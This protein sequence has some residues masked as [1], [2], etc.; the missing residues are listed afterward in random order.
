MKKFIINIAAGILPALVLVSSCSKKID[1]AYANPNTPVQATLTVPVKVPVESLLPGIIGCMVGSS[2]VQGSAYG[3][4]NDGLYIGRYVQYW[5]TS[6]SGNQFDQMGGATGA[7]DILGSVWAMH[8]YGMG[9]NLS[10][11]I[12][13]SIE[14]KKWDYAGVGYAIR[15]WSWLMLTDVYGEVI[16]KEAFNTQQSVFNYDPQADVYAKVKEQCDSAIFY[17]SKTG[18][19][20]SQANLAKGDAYFYNGDVNKWKKFA[21]SVMA[22]YY[23][24]Y[25]NKPSLYKPDSVIYYANLG[26][27]AIDDEAVA[28]FA[29]S[30][31]TGTS[32]FYGPLRN[33]VGALRQSRFISDLLTG[34]NPR[35]PG[36]TDPRAGYLIRENTNGTYK[37]VRPN[38]GTDGLVAADQP[39]SFWG[40]PFA[41]NAA[42]AND[43]NC[44]YIFRNG[45]PFPILTASEVMF[46]KAEAYLRKG[47][48]VNAL[49]AYQQGIG[50]SFDML[51]STPDYHTPVPATRQITPALKTAYLTN[52][53]VVPSAANLTLSHI[54]L[55]KF[56][57]MYGYGLIET[58]TDLRRYHYT[59]MDPAFPGQ[60][61][62]AGFAPPIGIDLFSNNNGKWVNRAR[63]R[64]NSEYLYNVAALSSIGA[65]ALDY[66][67]KEMWITQP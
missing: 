16:M 29:N 40:Q 39:V 7:S 20:V 54:M 26:I 9:L 6:A 21:Y 60:Q 31:I 57:A 49:A 17:L 41:T 55:Q 4:A 42:P 32:N 63:P 24:H 34:I 51:T 56:I 18:D 27:N 30:G 45:S 53:V 22:R 5:A 10:K 15:A 28:K 58:W 66:H 11:M 2:S 33:N 46:M 47:E 13:W 62:Y 37:G 43:N 61:V 3:I 65:L 8:Y 23:N 12:E 36:V 52:V 35:F 64:Y 19:N 44:R 25:S 38:K 14:E 50:L 1:D 59:D 67:T 48:N